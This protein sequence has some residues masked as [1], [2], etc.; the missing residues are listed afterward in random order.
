MFPLKNYYESIIKQEIV[1]ME[2][3]AALKRLGNLLACPVISKDS[4]DSVHIRCFSCQLE[5]AEMVP[6]MDRWIGTI[7]LRIENG[8]VR[9]SALSVPG[10]KN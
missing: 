9:E 8:V 2:K 3:E 1:G 10:D 4:K 5:G 7:A 6:N